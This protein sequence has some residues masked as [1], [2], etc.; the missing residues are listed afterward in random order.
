V[1]ESKGKPEP[2]RPSPSKSA[3]EDRKYNLIEQQQTKISCFKHKN[4]YKNCALVD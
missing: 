2:A 3:N 1:T 4:D